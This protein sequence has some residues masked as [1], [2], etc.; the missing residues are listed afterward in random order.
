MSLAIQALH[1]ILEGNFSM[2]A[3]K[4]IGEGTAAL[5]LGR[6]PSN[7]LDTGKTWQVPDRC[8]L[9]GLATSDESCP[10]GRCTRRTS[11]WE[12][13]LCDEKQQPLSIARRESGIPT[14]FNRGRSF[15]LAKPPM[16]GTILAIQS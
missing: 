8:D 6:I 10:A 3:G 4:A 16:R 5:T 9:E 12:R 15:S 14:L 11:V 1:R 2:P 7:G 13:D